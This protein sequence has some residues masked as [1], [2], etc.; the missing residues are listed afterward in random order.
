MKWTYYYTFE[1]WLANITN[2]YKDLHLL[3]AIISAIAP[4][5]QVPYCH[6]WHMGYKTMGDNTMCST[7]EWLEKQNNHNCPHYIIDVAEH[8]GDCYKL[9]PL[10]H[11]NSKILFY[12]RIFGSE[13]NCPQQYS[14]VSETILKKCGG[15]PFAIITLSSSLAHKSRNVRVC[16]VALLPL[17]MATLGKNS[18][19]SLPGQGPEPG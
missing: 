4:H 5:M 1:T 9:K 8:V 14:G 19:V 2:C 17:A 12:G 13:R 11:L 16:L 6:R 10:T 15:E 3:V 7:W 18:S